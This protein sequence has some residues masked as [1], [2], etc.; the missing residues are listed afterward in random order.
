MTNHTESWLA[1]FRTIATAAMTPG[2]A[3][4]VRKL[5]VDDGYT[6]RAVAVACH[7]E[8][9][10]NWEPAGHQGMGIVLCEAAAKML[11]ENPYDEPWN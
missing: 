1:E 5:R 4:V 9:G 10:G 2:R 8:W 6:W 7:T 11:G 3:R